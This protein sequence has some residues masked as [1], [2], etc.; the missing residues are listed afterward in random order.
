MNPRVLVRL[1]MKP[2][3]SGGRHA[4]FTEGYRPHFVVSEGEWLGVIATRCTGPVAPS[5]EADFEFELVYHPKVDY[6][7]LTVG[8][9]FAMHEGP[10]VVATGTVLERHEQL[11]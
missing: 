4:P 8:A 3:E 6:S 9:E 1:K 5:D 7:P 11:G 10:R 2:E